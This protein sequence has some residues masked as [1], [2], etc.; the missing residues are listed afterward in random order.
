MTNDEGRIVLI[1]KDD[2]SALRLLITITRLTNK[3]MKQLGV[4][5]CTSLLVVNI[6]PQSSKYMRY[7][8]CCR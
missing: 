2:V 3:D 8:S 1:F 4:K 6:E 5:K 7:S